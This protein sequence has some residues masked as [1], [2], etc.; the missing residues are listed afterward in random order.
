[1]RI[2][3]DESIPFVVECFSTIGEVKAVGSSRITPSA[4]ADADILLVR[5]VTD[6]NAE[7]LA[8][9]S[10]RFVAAATT[11]FDHIDTDYLQD[12]GIGFA[13]A[14]GSNANS[15]AEYSIAALLE[16]G[17]KYNLG[18]EGKSIGIIGVG[19]I[20]GRVA[21]KCA[22]L[23]MKVYLN[24]PPLQKQTGDAKYLP[25]EKLC[26]CDFITLHTPLTFEGIDRTF[27]LADE[28]F[29]DSLKAGCVFLNTSR[30]GVVDSDALKAAIR[31]GRL[32]AVVIDVWENEPNI[33]TELLEMVDIATP[34]IA[35][36]SL[37]G[38]VA[39]TIMAYE[40]AC[41]YLGLE[42][43]FDIE[44]F[45]PAPA[46]PR[47]KVNPN[48]ADEQD[49]LLGAVRKVYDIR[50]DDQR[51]RQILSEPA[52]KKPEF[53]HLLRDNYPVHREFADTRI[54]LEQPCKTLAAKLTG[55][56]FLLSQE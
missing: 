19:R 15:V 5:T 22:A 44:P 32:K 2:V 14:A 29:F 41:K 35:G 46:V 17:Q 6:V 3:A 48:D 18:L 54:V 27:H 24:D 56:G 31:A 47:L 34:H 21:K 36:Y 4:V 52:E 28:R 51:F 23:G 42:A 7:L 43:R 16:M 11:G 13:A 50:E 37:D 38:R 10:V 49:A 30:G 39:G 26:N 1:M 20:G 45:L 25:I 53:F 12:E 8:G 55:I 9:S 40:S 33:D